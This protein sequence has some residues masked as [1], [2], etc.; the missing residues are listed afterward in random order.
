MDGTI[1]LIEYSEYEREKVK[2]IMENVGEYEFVEI[3]NLKKFYG[4]IEDLSSI[5]LIIMDI[6]F[7]VE[8][9]GFEILSA[10]RK[11]S[12]TYN[13][14]IIIVTKSDNVD[15]RHG[16]L[17]FK[18]SDFVV[19]PYQTKRLENSIRSVL[20]IDQNFRYDF[21][22]ANVITMSIE[23]YIT[24]EFKIASRANQS[25]SIILITPIDFK[26]ETPGPSPE[27]KEKIYK[28]ATEKV[29]LSLRS[30][31]TAILN[32]NK[33]IL[34]VLP[35][36]NSQGAQRVLEKVK[37]NVGEGLK[38]LNVKYNDFYYAVHV[39]F[40]ND[41]K[42]FQNLMERAIKKV[43]DKIMLEK[44]TSIGANALDNARKTYKR[45]NM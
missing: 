10:I 11:N 20:K 8:K 15:Y 3:D 4:I 45:F 40:P 5:S 36:T 27:L 44:I 41:G 31:D 9:E 32:A 18:V 43:E 7:P 22:S 33:D 19:K 1:L 12:N 35:F 2:I 17:K 26:R 14:P 42:N 23:D 34:V 25:L 28:A 38:H 13:T 16:A 29:K 6:A 39:T 30:T 24:K 21:D 37:D